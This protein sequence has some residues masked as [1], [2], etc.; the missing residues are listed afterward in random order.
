MFQFSTNHQEIQEN[1]LEITSSFILEMVLEPHN[2][3]VY[4]ELLEH[5]VSLTVKTLCL[6]LVIH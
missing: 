5:Q 2:Y 4:Q 3:A 6:I 1:L